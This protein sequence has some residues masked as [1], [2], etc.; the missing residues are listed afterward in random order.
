MRTEQF[1]ALIEHARAGGDADA[2]A[3]ADRASAEL[4][5]RDVAD[6]VGFDRHLHRVMAASHRVDLWGA[7]YLVN[8]GCSDD[9]FEHFRGWLVTQGR[10]AFA[11]AVAEP[12]SLAD[13][14]SVRRA[15]VS[16][17]ELACGRMLGVAERAHQTATG[18][19]LPP[20]PDRGPYPEL[21]DFWDF[22]DEEE[23]R[24]RVPRL[25]ALFAEPP[26]E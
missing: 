13:L 1:W 22:D 24:R 7:A 5:G 23:L 9:G 8:G 25:A 20:D 14:P 3:V 21:G 10:A 19:G 11:R 2:D 17:E 12:D 6:I 18:T 16:G 15:A 26:E 4:A